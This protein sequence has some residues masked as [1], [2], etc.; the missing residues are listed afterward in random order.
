MGG[1]IATVV[2]FLREV[3]APLRQA[4]QIDLRPTAL[5]RYTLYSLSRGVLALLI[6]YGFALVF[7]WTAARSRAAERLLLPLLD[8]LQSIPV[9]GFLPGFVLG[10]M[11]LF[12]TRNVGLELA[13]ILMIF[14]AQAWN[15]A[16]SFYNS[17][18]SIPEPLRDACR[19]AGWGP[20]R[21]FRQCELPAAAQGLVWNGMLSMAGGWVFLMGDEAFRLGDRDAGDPARAARR[22]RAPRGAQ[23]G[24][25]VARRGDRGG[26]GRGPVADR[27][28]ARAA[29][30]GG[31]APARVLRRAH[32]LPSDG[33]GAPRHGLGPAGGSRDRALGAAGAGT[34]ARHPG[35]RVVPRAD[36]LPRRGPAVRAHRGRARPGR[37]RADGPR[38]PV[39]RPVQRHLGGGR[40]SRAAQGRGHGV[41]AA[42]RRP[43]AHAVPAGRVPGARDGVGDGGG[44]CVERLDRRRIHRGRWR[45]ARDQGPR[46][47]DQRSHRARQLPAARGRDRADEPGR[48]GL[49]PRRVAVADGVGAD[50]LRVRHVTTDMLLLEA[51]HVTQR[52][53]LPNGQVLEA[54]RDV[55][56]AVREHEV[57]ALVGPSGC[58]KSTLL[59]LFAGLARPADG[60][61]R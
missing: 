46:Q 24:Q 47:P 29:G 1:V 55:S 35:R 34:A 17:L 3:E 22:V 19:I 38:R 7:G 50:A 41:P 61:L 25:S 57:V 5:V 30:L 6:S 21:T 31:V 20:G 44:R 16:L 54:L 36:A 42:D 18:K 9:L 58:G 14:T 59:R 60:T 13:A 43:V 45:A 51:R 23:A 52:F 53:R 49:E 27:A 15:L 10:L 12:P 32:V 48:R 4:V 33:G 8:I 2:A 26:S 11:A 39:V 56:L 37:G 40:D 28:V